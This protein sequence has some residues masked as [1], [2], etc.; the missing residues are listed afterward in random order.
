M[1][2]MLYD[3]SRFET[4]NEILGFIVGGVLGYFIP[5]AIISRNKVA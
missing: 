1:K 4:M 3:I 5:K 2:V